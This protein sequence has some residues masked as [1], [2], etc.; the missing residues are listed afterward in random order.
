MLRA[1][2]TER[3]RERKGGRSPREWGRKSRYYAARHSERDAQLSLPSPSIGWAAPRPSW[4]FTLARLVFRLDNGTA[5]GERGC[6]AKADTWREDPCV[7]RICVCDASWV[8]HRAARARTCARIYLYGRIWRSACGKLPRCLRVGWRE[9][10]FNRLSFLLGRC[11][12]SQI[13][14]TFA[15]SGERTG[16]GDFLGRVGVVPQWRLV[17]RFR[18]FGD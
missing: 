8:C 6:R 2:C 14:S 9:S 7:S 16:C 10:N 4:I 11:R 15:A 3:E 5:S 13:R 17:W 18:R 1:R 12:P